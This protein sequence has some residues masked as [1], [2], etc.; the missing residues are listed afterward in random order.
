MCSKEFVWY[1]QNIPKDEWGPI[2]W[3]WL[4]TAAI[5]YSNEPT[6]NEKFEMISRFWA[7]IISIPCCECRNHATC[8]VKK[9]TPN[10]INSDEFQ[11]WAWKFHNYVN[12]RLNKG[13]FDEK[14]YYEKYGIKLN[15]YYH[16]DC[17]E[18]HY[19]LNT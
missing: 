12:W 1:D 8:Y 15:L 11:V 10:F 16:D 4:H 2:A 3:D 5:N 17:T 13:F 14:N 19:E 9:C 7:F 18:L 6:L